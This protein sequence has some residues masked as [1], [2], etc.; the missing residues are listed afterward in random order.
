MNH[1]YQPLVPGDAIFLCFVMDYL[2]GLDLFW[3]FAIALF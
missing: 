1:L 2:K 3:E